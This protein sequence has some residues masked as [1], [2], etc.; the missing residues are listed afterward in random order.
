LNAQTDIYAL[1]AVLFEMLTGRQRTRGLVLSAINKDVPAEL[2]HT[3]TR[4]LSANV[5][6]RAQSAATIAAELRSIAAMLDTR[7]EAEEAASASEPSHRRAGRS[8]SGVVVAIIL[9][10]VL[11]GV[12]AVWRW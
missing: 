4:M 11:L 2:E 12:L 7:T 3:V 5:E 9:T 6:N 10:L 1:G 8:R